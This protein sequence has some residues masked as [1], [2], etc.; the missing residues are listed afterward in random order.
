MKTSR[1]DFIKVS[2]LG[3]GGIAV[4][5][6][7]LSLSGLIKKDKKIL[8]DEKLTKIP[9]Y[10]DVCFW[11]CAAWT[12]VDADGKIKKVL[13]NDTDSH[14]RGRLCPRGTG[15]IGSYYDDDRL[16]TP[17]IRVEK[18]GEQVFEEATW[19]EAFDLIAEK[20]CDPIGADCL[21][22]YTN[23]PNHPPTAKLDLFGNYVTLR[24]TARRPNS[25]RYSR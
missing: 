12:Y 13:G 5:G 15:G 10:C 21:W 11:K 7:A 18:N 6:S 19:E 14:C 8:S 16:K 4:S 22:Q 17:L 25:P 23:F 24:M 9:T 3:M 1:R 20:I 2:S